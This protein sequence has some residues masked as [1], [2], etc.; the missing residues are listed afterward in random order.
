MI[1]NGEHPARRYVGEW[2]PDAMMADGFD[3]ALIGIAERCGWPFLAVY[4]GMLCVHI[5]M[6]RD[7]MSRED[8]EEYLQSNVIGAWVGEQTPIFVWKFD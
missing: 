3:D 8:A 5:L 1:D 6:E 2:N 7:G 4:D